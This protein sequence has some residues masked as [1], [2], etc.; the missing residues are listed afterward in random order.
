MRSPRDGAKQRSQHLR[1]AK[2]PCD[3]CIDYEAGAA[4]E[5]LGQPD[6]AIARYRRVLTERRSNEYRLFFANIPL[7]TLRLAELYDARGDRANAAEYYARLVA[8]WENAD[9]HLQPRVAAA[10][11][12]LA[13]LRIER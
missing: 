1:A 3:I 4:F 9:P 11:K 7:I 8:A 12:R 5:A 6:S 2:P 10:R 13:E